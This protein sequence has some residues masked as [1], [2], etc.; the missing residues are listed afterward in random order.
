MKKAV[1]LIDAENFSYK[2]VQKLFEKLD[3]GGFEVSLKLAFADWTQD[4]LNTFEWKQTLN[5]LSIRP[6]HL[7]TYSNGKNASDIQLVIHGMELLYTQPDIDYFIIATSDGDFTPLVLKLKENGK[8]VIGFGNAVS[9]Q[10][11]SDSCDEYELIH[12]KQETT[13]EN[14]QQPNGIKT[15]D[16]KKLRNILLEIW[17]LCFHDQEGWVHFDYINK[18]SKKSFPTFNYKEYA[19]SSV[20]EMIEDCDIFEMHKVD[21]K[22]HYD[23]YF[24]PR[25]KLSST[26]IESFDEI[27]F[28]NYS[29][30]FDNNWL[31]ISFLQYSSINIKSH[32]YENFVDALN[33]SYL[34]EVREIDNE[35]GTTD[36]YYRRRM[37]KDQRHVL[38]LFIKAWHGYRK[39]YG[40]KAKTGDKSYIPLRDL[41]MFIKDN[42]EK[43]FSAKKHNF[44]SM[45]K[46][47]KAMFPLE[48]VEKEDYLIKPKYF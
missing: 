6:Q 21:N 2:H 18:V 44:S 24:K 41:N 16:S 11:L 25:E 19:Y 40:I 28:L 22:N 23:H 33:I 4:N 34:Y 45:I 38:F 27:Y 9:S 1:L 36:I 14:K 7:F 32:D 29:E 17:K 42:L 15:V 43:D 47:L 10:V 12:L 3:K 8:K 39:E 30:Y 5:K 46:S 26:L 48:I 31:N 37:T 35:D 13:E 20:K